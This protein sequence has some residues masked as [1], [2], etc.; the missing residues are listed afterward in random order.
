L[1]VTAAFFAWRGRTTEI[2]RESRKNLVVV[3]FNVI[4]DN[5]PKKYLGF[6][7]ADTLITRLGRTGKISVRPTDEIQRY[8]N[9]EKNPLELGRRLNADVVLTGTVQQFDSRARLNV[10]LLSVTSGQIIWSSQFDENASDLFVLQDKLTGNLA[11]VLTLQ[12]TAAEQKELNQNTTENQEALKLYWQGRFYWSKR[13][14]EQ[15][16]KGIQYFE[17]AV[18]LDPNFA[19][20]YAGLAD[21]YALTAS[22]LPSEERFPKAI[23]SAQRALEINENL[24]EAHTSLA[25]VISKFTW[26][27]EV[28]ENH[29]KRAIELN[30]KYP[31]VH[32]WYGEFLILSGRFEEGFRELARAE[33]LDPLS[34]IIKTDTAEGLYRAR[35]Y[36]EALAQAKKVL[37]MSPDNI[38]IYRIIRRIQKQTSASEAEIVKTD[39]QAQRLSKVSPEDLA[40]LEKL[41]AEQNWKVY[42]DTRLRLVSKMKV[43]PYFIE[44]AEIYMHIGEKHAAVEQLS[45]QINNHELAPLVLR[46]EPIFDS[47]HSNQKFIL[48][49]QLGGLQPRK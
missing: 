11:E 6:G 16:Q 34:I 23:A 8:A 28:A 14:P 49:L 45:K 37:E 48:L 20:A 13:T 41:A 22:G 3:P 19:Q 46:E 31:G 17:E 30:E 32:H 42:W 4:S 38:Q 36:P 39:L 35:R 15:I 12:L 25:F 26:D 7:L 2:E 24:A 21:S 10:Q 47:L 40:L 5:E 43:V 18:R 1:V 33:K 27:R 29:Y 44:K 9:A